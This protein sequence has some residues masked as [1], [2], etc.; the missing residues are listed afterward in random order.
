MAVVAG[1]AAAGVALHAL[2]WADPS[3][4]LDDAWIVSRVARTWLE[5]G[6]PTWDATLPPVEAVSDPT[7][8]LLSVP[9]VAIG[10]DPVWPLRWLGGVLGCA[11]V[12]AAALLAGRLSGGSPRAAGATGLVLATS[13]G[14]AY[15]AVG[16]LETALWA[17][18]VLAA[19]AWIVGAVGERWAVVALVAL[20]WTRPEAPLVL[21]GLG[22]LAIWHR[23]PL[24]PVAAGLTAWVALLAARWITYGAL[25]PNPVYAKAPD[26]TAGLADLWAWGLAVGILPLFVAL[27]AIPGLAG[28]GLLIAAGVAVTGGDWMPGHRRFVDVSVLIA[29]GVGVAM[30][31]SRWASAA[32][33]A[34]M[35][36]SAVQAWRG[37]DGGAWYH[38]ELA[39][40]GTAAREA[41]IERIAAF[42]VGRLGWAFPGSIHDLA[43]LTD[44]RIGRA[45]GT[46]GQKPFDVSWFDARAPDWV[47]L[48]SLNDP[49]VEPPR[50]IRAEQV[51]F[52]HLRATWETVIVGRVG[53]PDHLI[54][55]VR[56]GS[57]V[58]P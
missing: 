50:F 38:A 34:W 20:A 33:V 36:G 54:I 42:D 46:H 28:L 57:P 11:V 7:W 19:A 14:F 8:V 16:G 3:C 41:G 45:P 52:D 18:L 29:V 1:L 55:M 47:M 26:P 37:L 39:E 35:L 5:T 2:R 53:S 10:L 49:T 17:G 43:G 27:R 56:P 30:A 9:L 58:P 44:A 25:W 24:S 31:R 4:A 48:T 23:R 40:M 12:F 13:G 32:V 22:V 6:V 51:V 21:L 15:H